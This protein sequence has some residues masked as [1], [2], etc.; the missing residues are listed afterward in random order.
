[1]KITTTLSRYLARTYFMNMLLLLLALLAVIY[2]FDTVELIRRAGKRPDV[3]LTLV[4]QM[5]LLKLPEVGQLLFPF[6]ILFSAMFTFWQLSRRYELVVVRAS[7]FSVWQFLAPVVGVA[8]FI[9]IFQVTVFNPVGSLLVSKYEQ[10]E[11]IHLSRQKNQIAVFKEGLWLR[12]R[13]DGGKEGENAKDKDGGYVILH[14]AKIKQPHWVLKNVT[15]LYFDENDWFESRVDA[16]QATLEKG[17]WLFSDVMIYKVQEEVRN[18]NFYALPTQLTPED[19]EESFASP[20]TMSFWR[21]PGYIQ[22]L[23]ETG[24]DATRLRVYYQSLL[25]QPLMFAA[26]VLLAATVSMRPPRFRGGMVLFALGVFIGFLVFFMSSFLQALG[27][28]GQIPTI[29]AAWSPALICFL[30]GVGVMMNL[31]DG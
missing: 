16:K 1:M 7:G 29:L 12:Q 19:I 8:V 10:L 22:T 24:F 21:L 13:A 25:S 15:V 31:E 6:A 11:Q 18:E 9:G 2:L 30:S 26:M 28:S 20:E 23:E 4:L 27:A 5:S 14:A 17:R 3:P